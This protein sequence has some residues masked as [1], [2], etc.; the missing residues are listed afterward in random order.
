MSADEDTL[1]VPAPSWRNYAGRA[2]HALDQADAAKTV[3]LRSM[4]LR[5]AQVLATLAAAA[6]LA[7]AI[8]E[9]QT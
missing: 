4:H 7:T 9:D 1:E 3:S 8:A 6:A 5:Q 2:E